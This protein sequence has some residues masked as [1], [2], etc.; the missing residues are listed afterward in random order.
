MVS[1]LSS[2]RQALTALSAA[3]VSVG[4]C[5]SNGPKP[6]PRTEQGTA[7]SGATARSDT[8]TSAAPNG[9]AHPDLVVPVPAASAPTRAAAAEQRA[10][11][12]KSAQAAWQFVSRS[13][14]TAGFVGATE[15][16]PY[17]TV[18]DIAST[19]ASTW[20]ARQLGFITAKQYKAR[21]ARAL[22]TIEGMPLFDGA[23][24]NKL[25]ASH[26]GAMVDRKNQT[27]TQGYGWSVIDHG[28]FLVWLKVIG[29]SDPDFAPRVQAIVAKLDMKRLVHDGYLYGED[30]DPANGARRSYQEGRVGYE[31]Y[32][33]EGFSLWGTRGEQALDFGANGRPATVE[34]VTVVSDA[35]KGDLLTSEPFVMMGL[36]LGWPGATWRPLSLAVLA[37]QE[38]RF[39]RT[40]IVTMVSEDAIPDPPAYFYYYLVY[41]NGK[42]FVVTSPGGETA[43]TF[44]RWVSAK[45]A[46][47]YHALAPSDYTWRALQVVRWGMTPNRGWTAGVYEGTQRSTR[48][49]NLNTAAIVLESAAYMQRGCPFIKVTCG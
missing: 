26:T 31:Q 11:M 21:T 23:A 49:F 22:T 44:P 3:F 15:T 8:R 37:A 48:S 17:M 43:E 41:S 24:Y 16:Y 6:V 39:K 4:A 29:Q 46:F 7:P 38:A 5:Q 32:A 28:R 30:L 34:G 12:R 47:G 1:I 40:G 45:A 35:R 25:Y 33:A 19:L 9:A 2:R 20:S 27:S 13:T 42:P 10:F 18:W 14:S 36:E